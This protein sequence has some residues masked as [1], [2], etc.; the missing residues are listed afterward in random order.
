ML[1]VKSIP[2]FNDNY[3]WL[4]HNNDNHC[5]VVDPGDAT[6][7]LKCIKEHDFI[8]DA[9]L[10]THHHHDHIGGVPELVRQFPNVNVVGPENEPI[11]TLTHPVGDGDFV[12]LFDEQFMVLGVPGHTNDHVAYIGDE[13]LFCG[14]ALF[15][16]GCGRLFEGTAEQM[17]NSLQ[18]MA[19]LPDE[20]EVYCAHEY[21]ASN[22]AF[23][24]AV[25]PDND[26]LLRYREKVLHLRAHGKSTIPSTLQRE[27]LINPF[28]RTSEANV[29]KSVASK[30][31][32]STEVEIFTALRRWK[33]EF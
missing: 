17:F 3:I 21:T 13:K 2:A 25:E 30:V 32:D 23:A 1:S 11:P 10:I 29:K 33:D 8:L 14:D 12:E 15:S 26:Y 7:V 5:V 9:I 27:K 6:P 22:L 4:I 20:T 19:A 16:A 18:K 24:L 28:L 31:Q